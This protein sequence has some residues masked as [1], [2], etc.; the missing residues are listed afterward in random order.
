MRDYT[1]IYVNTIYTHNTCTCR[2]QVTM[3]E[4]KYTNVSTHMPTYMHTCNTHIGHTEQ[5]N[6]TIYHSIYKHI[7]I[8]RTCNR[9]KSRY[10]S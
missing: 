5:E 8:A 4:L 7:C 9:K 2:R 3:Y 1:Y 6:D 10:T